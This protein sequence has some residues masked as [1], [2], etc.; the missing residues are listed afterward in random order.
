MR[1]F[2]NERIVGLIETDEKISKGN[3]VSS[4]GCSIDDLMLEKIMMCDCSMQNMEET[5]H[6]FTDLE[7]CYD[8]QLANVYGVAKE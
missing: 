6:N 3:Y 5:V 2:V 8:R 1:A 7:S 4:K